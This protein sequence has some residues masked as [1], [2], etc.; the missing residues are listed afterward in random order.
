MIDVFVSYKSEDRSAA[1]LI[2]H[3]LEAEGLTVWWD[4]VLQAGQDYQDTIDTNLRNALVVVVL[5]SPLSVKSRW[6]R[7]EA[8]VADRQGALVPVMIRACERPLAFELVQ[9]ADLTRWHGER[10]A[11]EWRHFMND[12]HAK[13]A[14]RRGQAASPH[15]PAQIAASELEAL[16]WSSIKDSTDASDLQSYLSRY[17]NGQFVELA[18][19]RLDTR[20]GFLKPLPQWSKRAGIAA[21]T[22]V[23]LSIAIASWIAYFKPE[24]DVGKMPADPTA[25]KPTVVSDKVI[26]V[27]FAGSPHSSGLPPTM[28]S[29]KILDA[30]RMLGYSVKSQGYRATDFL[31]NLLKV[32]AAGNAPDVIFVDNYIHVEGGKTAAGSFDGMESNAA[33]RSRLVPVSGALDDL[34][35]GW[36]FLVAGSPDHD[37]A[38]AMVAELSGCETPLPSPGEELLRRLQL[39][40]EAAARDFL[41]CSKDPS[42]YDRAA[43]A[44]DCTEQLAPPRRVAVCKMTSAA[45]LAFV[46]TAVAITGQRLVGRRSIVSVHRFDD[47]WRL[48]AVS[49]DPVSVGETAG[50]WRALEPRFIAS[51]MAP[52]AATLQTPDGVLPPPAA[53]ERFGEFGWVPAKPGA[54]AQIVEM[55]YGWDTR[56]FLVDPAESHLST[57]KL[58]TTNGPWRWRIWTVG[59]DG[60]VALSETRSF[61]H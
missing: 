46:E 20:K 32:A 14:D 58:W 28:V 52:K 33:L 2:A 53:G 15:P 59:A 24:R 12:L 47:G 26:E 16:F 35:R 17:P 38:E 45:K 22:I 4:P 57:G 50:Q 40:A 36:E 25:I 6:V 49:S 7:S 19:R 23:A 42:L 41:Q 5:W 37:A 13:L 44:R 48:L 11:P 56:L 55:N 18:R 8:T 21:V 60:A 34:G 54:I 3:V 31:P 61:K 27:W 9:T 39:Q 1:E 51:G 30:A 29:Q 10:D 43:L